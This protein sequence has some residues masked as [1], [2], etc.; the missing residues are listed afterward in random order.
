MSTIRWSPTTEAALLQAFREGIFDEGHF[1]EAK[2]TVGESKSGR[3]ETARDLA[4]FAVDGGT[5]IIGVAEDK[6]IRQ[7]D[8]AP[9][10]LAGYAERV[11]QVASNLVDPP[12][13]L[14]ISEIP[15]EEKP[16]HGYLVVEVP[17][18]PVAPHMV[19][20]AYYERGEKTRVRLNDAQVRRF[21]AAQAD[22]DT[23]VDRLLEKEIDRDPISPGDR[24]CGHLYLVAHP[25][26]A[27]SQAAH[28]V[29]YGDDEAIWKIVEAG[30]RQVPRS[31]G[32]ILPTTSSASR[33]AQRSSGVARCSES[34]EGGR[35]FQRLSESAEQWMVDIEFRVDG[36]IRVLTGGI[37]RAKGHGGI[38]ERLAIAWALRLVHCTRLYADSFEYRGS[39]QLGIAA[40]RLHGL[41]SAHDS[42][43]SGP[44]YDRDVYR[45]TTTAT[46]FELEDRPRTVANRLVG[47]LAR[48][49]GTYEAAK[50]YLSY[51][52]TTG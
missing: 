40:N 23:L 10:P 39:W 48:A 17:A 6:E 47:S 35:I 21:H 46:H 18:S 36:G 11:E 9:V 26:N 14:R 27:T 13:T 34:L 44:L 25:I 24:E 37:T 42:W 28:D 22:Q 31:I 5:F 8:P 16:G 1:Y 12:L 7:F 20:G 41:G 19:D 3:K 43:Y 33:W 38:A 50:P 45:S 15:S 4:S 30:N 52:G 29:V 2:S 32:E 51:E 49:L